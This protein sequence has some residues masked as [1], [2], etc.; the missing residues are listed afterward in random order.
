MILKTW[1]LPKLSATQENIRFDFRY[2][3]KFITLF[4]MDVEF[5]VFIPYFTSLQQ[6][7]RAIKAQDFPTDIKD[8]CT[9]VLFDIF[10][11]GSIFP[12]ATKS[13][14]FPNNGPRFKKKKEEKRMQS[15]TT[16]LLT[17]LKARI[18]W[19]RAVKVKHKNAY[20]EKVFFAYF[21]FRLENKSRQKY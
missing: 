17:F 7:S 5:L 8:N 15:S 18:E 9:S 11:V 13:T 3:H 1:P 14:T 6:H 2:I 20:Q 19:R 21:F 12:L 10:R 4:W 16:T